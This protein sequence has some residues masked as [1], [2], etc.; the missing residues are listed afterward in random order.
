[1]GRPIGSKNKVKRAKAKSAWE[2]YNYWYDKYTKGYKQ[3]WFREKLNKAEFEEM[4]ELAKRAKVSN[5]ARA[6]AMSQEYVDRSFERK[7]KQL[8]GKK[9]G[10]IRDKD[11]RIKLFEDFID[12]AQANGMTYD[13]A[14]EEFERYFY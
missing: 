8:Y 1:M 13:E 14:R 5:P 2:T 11:T 10:D 4:Y 9:L 7:Y 12:E 6:V 3:G